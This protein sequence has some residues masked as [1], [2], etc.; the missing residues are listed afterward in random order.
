MVGLNATAKSVVPPASVTSA[1]ASRS[2]N[3]LVD[4]YPVPQDPFLPV[5][6][7]G[8]PVFLD[9]NGCVCAFQGAPNGTSTKPAWRCQGNQGKQNAEMYNGTSGKW[10][11]P[12]VPADLP[13]MIPY[14]NSNPPD[15]STPY[16]YDNKTSLL[17]P[18]AAGNGAS[19][20][21]YDAACTGINET[22]FSTAFYLAAEEEDAGVQPIDAVPCL[23]EGALPIRIQNVTAFQADGCAKGFFC[24]RGKSGET[25][26]SL[27]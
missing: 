8:G 17:V 14:D 1:P 23:R 15:L 24:M 13:S 16:I 26:R 7:L 9:D 5:E 10:F 12:K 2:T 19:L 6:P 22:T 25:Y 27:S 18:I 11:V 20:S 3:S 21:A 4:A